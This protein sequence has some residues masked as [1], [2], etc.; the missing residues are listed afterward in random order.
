MNKSFYF[1]L[2]LTP[3]ACTGPDIQTDVYTYGYSNGIETYEGW[4]QCD[5]KS[6]EEVECC[7]T[8]NIDGAI[9]TYSPYGYDS[10]VIQI[11]CWTNECPD[12]V[13]THLYN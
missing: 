7:I 4:Q 12:T 2:L 3:T 5:F 6:C 11:D 13:Y 1:L 10:L 9:I 8:S